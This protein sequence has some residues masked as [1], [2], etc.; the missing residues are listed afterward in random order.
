VLIVGNTANQK[1]IVKIQGNLS[2]RNINVGNGND[3]SMISGAFYQTSGTLNVLNVANVDNFRLGIGGGTGAGQN[4]GYGYY[5]LSG[6]AAVFNE[7]G[8]GASFANDADPIGNVGVADITGGT[9]EDN[10]WVTLARG[11]GATGI[12]NITGGVT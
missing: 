7:I 6:G 9:I 4:P 10:G 11:V 8:V 5:K 2:V 3:P 12:L 1:A